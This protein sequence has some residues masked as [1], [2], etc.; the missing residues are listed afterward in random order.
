MGRNLSLATQK[1]ANSITQIQKTPFSQR[2]ASF[3]P[4][5]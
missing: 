5:K 1:T 4:K 2:N 3:L